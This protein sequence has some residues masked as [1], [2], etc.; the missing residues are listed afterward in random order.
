MTQRKRLFDAPS[1]STCLAYLSG[2]SWGLYHALVKRQVK[3]IIIF[4]MS[5]SSVFWKYMTTR[6]ICLFTLC[7]PFVVLSPAQLSLA[8]FFLEDLPRVLPGASGLKHVQAGICLFFFICTSVGIINLQIWL[9]LYKSRHITQQLL[10]MCQISSE[11]GV[12]TLS[13]WYTKGLGFYKHR[14]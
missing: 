1:F 12:Y 11:L 4:K 8:V 6:A 3:Q 2:Q 5:T 9:K 7:T 10:N 13:T 14:N